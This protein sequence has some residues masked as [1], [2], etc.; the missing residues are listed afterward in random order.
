MAAV[1]AE[2]VVVL[3]HRCGEPGRDRFL[4][5]REVTRALH[6][7]LQKKVVGSLLAIADFDLQLEQP[8]PRRF[9]DLLVSLR[10]L[11]LLRDAHLR[12][13]LHENRGQTTFFPNRIVC[14]IGMGKTWSV[15]E[16][17]SFGMDSRSAALRP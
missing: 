7:I 6:Q 14:F 4:P 10:R 3:V 8:Q 17:A 13:C 9:W 12:N 16:Y 2:G 1:G 5:E 11:R 15:P